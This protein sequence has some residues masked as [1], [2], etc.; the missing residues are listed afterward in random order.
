VLGAATVIAIDKE[1]YRLHMAE[2]AGHTRVNFE[3]VD[4]RS[5]LLEMIGGRGPDKCID[6]VGMEAGH[7]A[8]HIHAYDRV[9]Q[10][11]RPETERPHAL[12]Q[13]IMACRSGGVVSVIG[14]YG[15]FLDKFP[16]GA[17]MNGR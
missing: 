14:V 11:V 13:A 1:P 3:E 17:R 5:R 7:G 10:A 16:A 9:K 6:A 4:V 8:A 15:G 2:R 12:R